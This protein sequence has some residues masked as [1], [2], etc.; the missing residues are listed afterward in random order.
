[1]L[2]VTLYVVLSASL[3][4]SVL[5]GVATLPDC[6]SVDGLVASLLLMRTTQVPQFAA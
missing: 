2:V 4:V 6:I 3:C 5:H 1:M